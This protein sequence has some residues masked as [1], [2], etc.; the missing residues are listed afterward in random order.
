M[1]FDFFMEATMNRNHFL[2]VVSW[3]LLFYCFKGI[4]NELTD[5]STLDAEKYQSKE[6]A[7]SQQV[8]VLSLDSQCQ[9]I[10]GS[11]ELLCEAISRGADLRIYTEFKYEEH[12][13]PGSPDRGIVREVSNFRVTYLIDKRWV[14]GIMNLRMP[15]ALPGFGNQPSWSFFMYNQ[16]GQQAIARPFLDGVKR[17][18]PCGEVPAYA[19]KNMPKYQAIDNY[20][21]G[22]NGP[23]SNFIYHFEIFKFYVQDNWREVYAHDANGKRLSGSF[24]DYMAAFENG[25]DM[26]VGISNLF[27][28]EG[29]LPYEV[30]LHCGP[31]YYHTGNGSY[32]VSTEPAVIVKPAIPMVY[33]TG[34][35][36]SG[37]I[38]VSTD[39][40]VEYWYYNPYT[41]QYSKK[42]D[43]CAIRYFVR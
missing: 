5:A 4:A 1:P 33:K 41:M 34:N 11:T 38:L 36:S 39:G 12:I 42:I 40:K 26:K 27:H 28:A 6:K 23:C 25:A 10:A 9:V 21:D 15:V 16:N 14:A 2:Y 20:D 7:M 17:P 32:C 3:F 8:P 13:I 30:F 43:H 22:S 18:E 37:N 24:N 35:W 31:G 29:D 19:P